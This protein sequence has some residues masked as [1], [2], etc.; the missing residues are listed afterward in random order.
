MKSTDASFPSRHFSRMADYTAKSTA[1][2]LKTGKVFPE[3]PEDYR[4]WGPGLALLPY[5]VHLQPLSGSISSDLSV[6]AARFQCTRAR[7]GGQNTTA[8]RLP[9]PPSGQRP[10]APHLPLAG[11]SRTGAAQEMP[12]PVLNGFSGLTAVA[13]RSKVGSRW[14]YS[15][16][17]LSL[18]LVS[19]LSSEVLPVNFSLLE[20]LC[21]VFEVFSY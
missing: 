3:N 8:P 21:L 15:W 19:S 11:I 10:H 7:R 5:S 20:V 18:C 6:S 4:N 16:P 2:V 9:P 13:T 1:V 12:R 17:L 14:R